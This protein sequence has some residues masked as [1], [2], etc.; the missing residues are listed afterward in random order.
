MNNIVV[1]NDVG[2]QDG[3]QSQ[4]KILTFESRIALIKS[5]VDAGLSHIEPGSFVFPKPCADGR[6]R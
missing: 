2:P 4:G 6:H 5:L 1:V 3:L